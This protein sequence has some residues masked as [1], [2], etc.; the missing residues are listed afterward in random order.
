MFLRK[1]L[2]GIG[3]L[4][5]VIAASGCL[6][7]PDES[8]PSPVPTSPSTVASYE[9]MGIPGEND[10]EGSDESCAEC[11]I[12]A[13]T[14]IT[15]VGGEHNRRC[16]FCHLQ[17]GDTPKCTDCHELVHGE[18]LKD[19]KDCHDEHAPLI[20]IPSSSY[21]Q[22]CSDCHAAQIEEF[23][24]FPGRH[25]DLLCY[26]CHQ[27]HGQIDACINCHAPHSV[28]ITYQDCLDC[29]PEHLP[30]EISY[31]ESIPSYTCAPCHEGPGI[32]LEQN[33]TRHSALSCAFCH[34][35]HAQI[36]ECQ[37]CHDPHS[38]DM[39]NEDCI[40]CHPAHNPLDMEFTVPERDTCAICH[41]ELD[42]ELRQ[43]NTIHDDLGCVYCHPEHRYVPTCESCHGLAHE[44]IGIHDDYPLCS[45]CH[46]VAHDV[47]NIVFNK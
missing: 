45:Q 40:R 38:Q 7:S 19:C 13:Y 35:A 34:K 16:M 1:A 9:E 4:M 36:P 12:N 39:N 11:H 10:E 32:L 31:P 28:Q 30:Q 44:R 26:Y 20:M 25:A 8:A 27:S 21:E 6:K 29:H 15:T 22:L 24:D 41:G 47:K 23:S 46:I 42:D 14:S 2:L 18:Q 3:I 33:S 37:L 43:S 17:H 5:L